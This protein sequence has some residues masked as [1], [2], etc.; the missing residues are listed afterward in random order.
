MPHR[1]VNAVATYL[2]LVYH[3]PAFKSNCKLHNSWCQLKIVYFFI[4]SSSP[5]SQSCIVGIVYYNYT[6]GYVKSWKK[7]SPLHAR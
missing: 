2:Y 7:T 3:Y 5:A 1:N 6:R 4:S